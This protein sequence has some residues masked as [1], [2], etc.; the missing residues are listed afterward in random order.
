MLRG[1]KGTEEVQFWLPEP[2]SRAIFSGLFD[3]LAIVSRR[4][5]AACTDI[6]N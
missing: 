1:I 5:I 3:V 4:R 2:R 6:I